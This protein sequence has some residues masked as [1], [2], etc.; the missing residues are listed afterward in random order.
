MHHGEYVEP[1]NWKLKIGMRI[2]L[3]GG[4]SGGHLFPLIAV[5]S[6]LKKLGEAGGE[7]VELYYMGPGD[8]GRDFLELENIKVIKVSA[9]KWRRYAS[10][11]NALDI[12]KVPIG[13]L[14]ALWSLFWIMPD[15]IFSKGGYGSLPALW[16]SRCYRI[17]VMIHESDSIPGVAN[18]YAGAFAKKIF[19]S[20]E[21]ASGLFS[22]RKAVQ[23]GNP[24]REGLF[25]CTR[26]DARKFLNI[27][28][29]KPLLL[30]LG[31]SQGAQKINE[32]VVNTLPHLLERYEIIHQCG[33]G[34]L[35]EVRELTA[36][37]YKPELLQGYHLA[38][39][40]GEKELCA[41]YGACDLVIS[42]AGANSIF[43][44]A[45]A[46]KPSII[47]PLSGSAS[48]HQFENAHNYAKGGACIVLD[49]QNLSPNLFLEAIASVMNDGAKQKVMS[50]A[51]K[52]F[53]RPDAALQ[54]AEELFDFALRH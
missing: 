33:P 4:G 10:V 1:Q 31:G 28:F 19:T 49:E 11:Y 45:R 26:E 9:A 51:A 12:L 37:E 24:V 39:F 17:P 2:L 38:G 30:V 5:G 47:I 34:N 50:D 13:M 53:S 3:T 16:A 22:K 36:K 20:F 18:R 48:N 44:V 35:E 27:R 23:V 15:A 32:I 14:K 42:R 7:P 54:I 40:L 43:E 8:F 29:T 25:T 21:S 52:A 41:A 46:G 6:Q